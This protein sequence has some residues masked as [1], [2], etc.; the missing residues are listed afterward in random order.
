MERTSNCGVAIG[1]CARA[2]DSQRPRQWAAMAGCAGSITEMP[3]ELTENIDV[4]S[5]EGKKNSSRPIV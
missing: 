2:F 5:P 1:L 4:S 3:N